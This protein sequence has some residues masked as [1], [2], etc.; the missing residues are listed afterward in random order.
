MVHVHNQSVA[1]GRKIEK[2]S[3]VSLLRNNTGTSVFVLPSAAVQDFSIHRI[4]SIEA[5]ERLFGYPKSRL[6]YLN[7]QSLRLFFQAGGDQ[8]LVYR[9]PFPECDAKHYSKG[10]QKIFSGKNLGFNRRTGIYQLLD[11]HEVYDVLLAPTVVSLADEATVT[12]C[13]NILLDIAAYS[14]HTHVLIDVPHDMQKHKT[15]DFVGRFSSQLGSAYVGKLKQHGSRRLLPISPLAAATLQINDRERSIEH[16]P[17]NISLPLHNLEIDALCEEQVQTTLQAGA[18]TLCAFDQNSMV[19]WGSRTLC[20]KDDYSQYIGC[21]RYIAA[22]VNALEELLEPFVWTMVTENERSRGDALIG[23]FLDDFC[24]PT[25]KKSSIAMSKQPK[26]TFAVED[27]DHGG[28]CFVLDLAVYLTLP[29][30]WVDI[31]MAL[32]G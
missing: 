20:K 3:R 15:R 13:A 4:T 16:T 10:F 27:D 6:D 29:M 18:N 8:C 1:E 22:L 31:R 32:S 9:L 25:K 23:H 30:T 19:I 24:D 17:A 28:K 11:Y 21:S 14:K 5:A 2:L 7:Y 12:H 26:Y